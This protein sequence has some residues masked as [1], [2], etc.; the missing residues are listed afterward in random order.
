[1]LQAVEAE[2]HN[3]SV[4]KKALDIAINAYNLE[5]SLK[6]FNTLE[7]LQ[8]VDD[9]LRSVYEYKSAILQRLYLISGADSK[10]FSERETFL[11]SEIRK[12][13]P[14]LLRRVTEFYSDDAIM[15]N[16]YLNADI[17][18]SLGIENTLIE[19]VA[20]LP[21]SPVDKVL[22]FTCEPHERYAS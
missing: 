12:V 13:A 19:K 11:S 7:S 1:M 22:I 14:N 18:T 8:A 10:D 5:E 15:L 6:L 9:T 3:I 2:P 17:E 4:L 20:S 16:F 21:Y